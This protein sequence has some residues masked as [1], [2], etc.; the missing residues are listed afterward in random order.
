MINPTCE[1][2]VETRIDQNFHLQRNHKIARWE[3][4]RPQAYWEYRKAW[5]ENP[6]KR[7]LNRYPIH[8]DVEATNQCNLKCTMCPRTS[9]VEKGTFW[10]INSTTFE[11]F[12]R[13]IDG[14]VDSGLRSVKFNY[15]GEPTLHPRLMDMV[16]Y[17]KKK[18]L[19]DVMFNTNATTL[20]E[21][22]TRDI[23]DSG[24]DKLLFSFDSPYREDFNAI[25]IGADYDRI[26]G[27]IKRFM[28][29]RNEIGR[30][31][32]FTRVTMVRMKNNY[33]QC[34]AFKELF[35]PIVDAVAFADYLDHAG[36]S[37]PE[38]MLVSQDSTKKF[39]CP[40]LWQRM[41][42][43]PDGE[44]TVCCM[45]SVRSMKVGNVFEQ[46]I[47][48]IWLGDKYQRI[49]EL[50]T[51]GRIDDLPTCSRCSLAKY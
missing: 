23:L 30:V 9:M 37:N 13:F 34:E 2:P 31:T 19:V 17:A 40:Q 26:L 14:G 6:M 45:D 16:R 29:K 44:C 22:L 3:M 35:E 5:D 21:S 10:E 25:R 28:D 51:T 38:K 43:H 49:R 1:T 8:L 33:D 46:A 48:D 41:F 24:L 20:T 27:N 36:Q 39:C 50:H 7:V 12:K 11:N 15:Y 4:T 32:P 47:E 18:G 42:I